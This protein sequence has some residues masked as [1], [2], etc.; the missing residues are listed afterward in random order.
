M[1]LHAPFA[2]E[3]GLGRAARVFGDGLPELLQELNEAL[4]A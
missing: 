3:G 2:E 1:S 4:A